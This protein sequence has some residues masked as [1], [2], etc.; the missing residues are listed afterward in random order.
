MFLYRKI[1]VSRWNEF[2]NAKTN[3]KATEGEIIIYES[4]LYRF[5]HTVLSICIVYIN[6]NSNQSDCA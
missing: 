2:K 1:I 5:L 4:Q 3:G 6:W